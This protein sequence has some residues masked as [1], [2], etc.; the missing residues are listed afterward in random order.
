MRYSD[1][2]R[3]PYLTPD[4]LDPDDRDLVERDSNLVKITAYTPGGARA[5]NRLGGWIRSSSTLDARLREM[6]ILRVGVLARADY[7]YT[8]HI[9]L[10]MQFGMS[11]ADVRAVAEG[12][13]AAGL[14]EIEEL[15]LRAADEITL[16]GA[17]AADTFAAL[18]R[19]LDGEQ[20]VEFTLAVSYYNAVTRFLKTFEIDVEDD[21]LHY[22]DDFPYSD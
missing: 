14:G 17:M 8:H 5:F 22:L 16:D 18:H 10:G 15:V 20:M 1:V 7:E 9:E 19:H 13:G 11:E 21:Y 4:D 6:A 2:A 3:L 12:P